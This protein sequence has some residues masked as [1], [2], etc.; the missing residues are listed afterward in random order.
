[1][2]QVRKEWLHRATALQ[3]SKRS[4]YTAAG[5][6]AFIFTASK[7]LCIYT[8]RTFLPFPFFPL[9]FRRPTPN[10]APAK[11]SHSSQTHFLSLPPRRIRIKLSNQRLISIEPFFLLL[12]LSFFFRRSNPESA[13][14]RLP[15]QHPQRH[16]IHLKHSFFPFPPDESE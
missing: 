9:P 11:A 15:N 13:L 10:P 8:N 16:L 2:H 5:Y 4:I 3:G 6:H 14:I 12:Y 7:A 1:M